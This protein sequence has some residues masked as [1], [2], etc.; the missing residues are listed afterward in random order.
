MR[1]KRKKKN[2]KNNN[3][4]NW[5]Q[6]NQ[7]HN[8]INQLPKI[9]FKFNNNN[10]NNNNKHNKHN[11]YNN[12]LKHNSNHNSFNKLFLLQ[13][14]KEIFNKLHNFLNLEH[15]QSSKLQHNYLKDNQWCN[16]LIYF[17]PDQELKHFRQILYKINFQCL[18]FIHLLQHLGKHKINWMD[19]KYNKQ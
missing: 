10:H 3:K 14:H 16:P 4:N 18:N 1:M 8:L 13:L 6:H 5:T 7:Y 17:L 19:F 11:N 2:H 12:S 9:P 15:K